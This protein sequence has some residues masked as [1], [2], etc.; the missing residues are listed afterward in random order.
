MAKEKTAKIRFW[1]GIFLSV[2]SAIVGVLFIVQTWSIYHSA[3]Q[4][5]YTVENIRLHF[6][7]IAIPVWLWVAAILGNILL[8]YLYP[9]VEKRP[10]AYI[11]M[12]YAL[13]KTKKRLS[14]NKELL[15]ATSS[16]SRKEEKIRL[17]VNVACAMLIIG[18]AVIGALILFDVLYQPLIKTEFFSAHGGVVDKLFQCVILSLIAMAA[19]YLA[20]VLNLNSRTRERVYY[21]QEMAKNLQSKKGETIPVVAEE[22]VQA[23]ETEKSIWKGVWLYRAAI[24]ALAIV[25]LIVG[26]ANGGMKEVFLKAINI[27]TQ[28]IGLG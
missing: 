1:Y 25:L 9:E 8:S 23:K 27:C 26:V 3:P 21:L 15:N 6:N 12:T 11:N 20:S 16:V 4:S 14:G 2:F 19:A 10:K 18:L 24:F 7:Q 17:I 22:S 5:P 28:C 13:S